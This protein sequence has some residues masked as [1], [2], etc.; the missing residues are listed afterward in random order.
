MNTSKTAP[1]LSLGIQEYELSESTTETNIIVN[2]L[3]GVNQTR[4]SDLF[5]IGGTGLY[6][7]GGMELGLNTGLLW[8]KEM[9]PTWHIF[10]MPRVHVVLADSTP[11]MFQFTMGAKFSL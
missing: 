4:N 3:Y 9:S 7:F 5:L 2:A 6:D 10:G 11:I 8:R 1:N